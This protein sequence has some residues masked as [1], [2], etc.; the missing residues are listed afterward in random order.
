MFTFT[1]Y[2]VVVDVVDVVEYYIVCVV[3]LFVWKGPLGYAVFKL[4]ACICSC[5]KVILFLCGDSLVKKLIRYVPNV[6]GS[7]DD[8]TVTV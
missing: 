7:A 5:W 1:R 4:F 6:F 8:D 3:V 2:W